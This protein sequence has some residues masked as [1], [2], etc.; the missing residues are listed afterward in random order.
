[1]ATYGRIKEFSPDTHSMRMYLDEVEAYFKANKIADDQKAMV[2][3]SS[4]GSP[5]FMLLSDLMSLHSP[6]SKTYEQITDALLK[7]CEPWRIKIAERYA[8][9]ERRQEAGESIS[10]YATIK[11][12]L[13]THCKFGTYLPQAMRDAFIF[14]IPDNKV[15][16]QLLGINELSYEKAQDLALAGEA[17]AKKSK[18]MQA[19]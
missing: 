12:K 16:Q 2:L 8:F 7:H 14:G 6:L 1:M 13:A 5:T 4:I 15:H 9:Y 18:E 11:H 17:A 10:E 19:G 3:L